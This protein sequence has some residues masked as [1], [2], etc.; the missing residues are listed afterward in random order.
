MFNHT[1]KLLDASAR[2]LHDATVET[3]SDE[4]RISCAFIAGY[5]ILQAIQPPHSGSLADHPLASIVTDGAARL[6]LAESDST[7]ALALLTWDAYGRYQFQPA[8]ATVEGAV[9][10]AIRVRDA[11]LKLRASV[12]EKKQFGV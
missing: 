4:R 11:V 3:A 10:W 2:W 5:N 9:A 6:G 12:A 8:P 1:E 7:L